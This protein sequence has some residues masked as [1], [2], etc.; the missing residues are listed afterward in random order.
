MAQHNAQRRCGTVLIFWLSQTRCRTLRACVIVLPP[1]RAHRFRRSL[2]H[3]SSHE[4]L[5]GSSLSQGCRLW[6]LSCGPLARLA[7]GEYGIRF[8]LFGVGAQDLLR[9][10]FLSGA[11][12]GN[13]SI[14][15]YEL[16]RAMN[17]C[18]RALGA[19]SCFFTTSFFL[20]AIS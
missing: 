4:S 18:C 10:A 12:R 1:I 9:L 20:L 17:F 6:H 7:V 5:F 8:S 16:V 2:S 3:E 11:T 13:S 15:M 19:T 14:Q